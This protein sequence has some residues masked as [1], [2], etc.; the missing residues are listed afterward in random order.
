MKPPRLDCMIQATDPP[1]LVPAAGERD[2][3]D[4]TNNHFAYRCTPLSIANASGWELLNPHDVTVIWTGFNSTDDIIIRVEEPNVRHRF[5]SS[6]FGHGI[7]TFHPGYVFRTDPGW[8]VLARGSPN[9]I[10]DG[11]HP[12]D[13]LVETNWL[14]FS[15]T[16]NWKFTRPGAVRFVKGEPFCFITMVPSVTIESVKP[17]IRPMQ[18]DPEFHKEYKLWS[19]ER[20]KFNAALKLGDELTVEQKWQKDYLKGVSTSGKSKADENHRV[21]RSL[22]CPVHGHELQAPEKE[23]APESKEQDS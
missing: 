6:T 15:F 20:N 11:I 1:Q 7:V 22:Q 18:E 13:G 17:V 14:P 8:M 5:I 9:R 12:L 16:M 2:W 19:S 4:A 21:K 3:M 10:K 23:P